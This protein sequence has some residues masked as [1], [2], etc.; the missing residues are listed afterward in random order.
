MQPLYEAG[1]RPLRTPQGR[2]ALACCKGVPKGERQL[3]LWNEMYRIVSPSRTNKLPSPTH[4]PYGRGQGVGRFSL[5]YFFKGGQ[6]PLCIPPQGEGS[7]C[8]PSTRRGSGL[9]CRLGRSWTVPTGH[10]D[11]PRTPRKGV[12]GPSLLQKGFQRGS[13]VS[14]AASVGDGRSP[15]ATIA[16]L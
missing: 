7:P 16:P 5:R 9:G 8:N 11:P 10:Q 1:L 2:S 13:L 12:L 6:A 3:P 14:A 4:F 15:L